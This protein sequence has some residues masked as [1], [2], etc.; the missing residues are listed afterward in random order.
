MR[1]DPERRFAPYDEYVDYD[2]ATHDGLLAEVSHALGAEEI[3]TNWEGER[4]TM[5]WEEVYRSIERLGLNIETDECMKFIKRHWR[6][7]KP[8]E[9]L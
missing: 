1:L 2:P 8:K 4:Q 5:D 6:K 7:G 9:A 3:G